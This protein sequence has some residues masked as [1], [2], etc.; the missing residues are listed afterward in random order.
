VEK[1]DLRGR[2]EKKKRERKHWGVG[3]GIKGDRK[4]RRPRWRKRKEG[5]RVQ[6]ERGPG[7][8]S[9]MSKKEGKKKVSIKYSYGA[10]HL[11]NDR[12]GDRA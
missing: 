1:K 2:A 3:G 4:L 12:R 10:D 7:L 11:K 8:K 5:G 9:K 6:E